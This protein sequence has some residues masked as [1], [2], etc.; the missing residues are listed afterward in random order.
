V[1]QDP[2]PKTQDPSPRTHDPNVIVERLA[3]REDLDAVLALEDASFNNPTTREWYEAE[4]RRP[5]VCFI[6]VLRTPGHRVAAFCA[7]WLV[8]GEAHINNLAVLP[9]LRSRGLGT[10]LLDAIIAEAAHLG[11][12]VLSLEVRE[13]NTPALRLY[14]KA[15]FRR[16]SVRKDYYTNPIENAL[17]LSRKTK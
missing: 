4:L 12:E 13:S 3:S 1:S 14:E 16:A 8:V 11:A 2:S 6:Y 7:F 9:E 5:E 17:I 15:G 10:Q